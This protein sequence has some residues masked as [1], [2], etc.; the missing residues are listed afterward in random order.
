M[1]KLWVR[2][3][4]EAPPGA[5]WNLLT[6]LESWPQWG[7]SVRKVDLGG[8]RLHLG[9]KGTITTV[10]G[11]RLPFEITEFDDGA[12]WA[13][14]VAGVAATDHTVDPL[15]DN[16]CRV[17]FGVPVLAAPYLAVCRVALTRLESMASEKESEVRVA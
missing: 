5:V 9:A 8:E 14:K 2:R 4:I 17:G 16:R 11:F 6:N 10:M 13:W 15:G 3:A 12:H 1:K 7:P